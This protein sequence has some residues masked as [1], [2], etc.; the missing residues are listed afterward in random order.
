MAVKS[1]SPL[2][3]KV[4]ENG[5]PLSMIRVFLSMRE[6]VCVC[7][8]TREFVLLAPR[9]PL[10]TLSVARAPGELLTIATGPAWAVP[11]LQDNTNT[12]T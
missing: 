9:E 10:L 7:V 11:L 12:H 8:C 6:C 4:L 5:E 3:G 2:D 1:R